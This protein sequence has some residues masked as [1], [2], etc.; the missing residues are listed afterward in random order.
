MT[1]KSHWRN[2]NMSCFFYFIMK[3]FMSLCKIANILWN[4]LTF[5]SSASVGFDVLCVVAQFFVILMQHRNLIR[6]VQT[7]IENKR[8]LHNKSNLSSWV[9]FVI[10]Q[11]ANDG[12]FIRQS[13]FV[14]Y[15]DQILQYGNWILQCNRNFARMTN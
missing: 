15:G 11:L 8:L 12:I 2:E 4:G 13:N 1:F 7:H 14:I 9:A 10:W 5:I 6:K 3:R